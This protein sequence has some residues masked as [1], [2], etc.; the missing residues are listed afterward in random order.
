MNT[1]GKEKIMGKKRNC[2]MTDEEKKMHERAIKLRKMTDAQLCEFVERTYGR[3]MEEG[4]KLAETDTP[5]EPE[6][7]VDG[8][9]CVKAFIEY[10]TGRVGTGNRIGNGTILQLNRELEKAISGGL[11]TEEEGNG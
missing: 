11:F 7:V 8:A 10:L 1:E 5:K 2:R 3:G 4:A 9:A 6:K